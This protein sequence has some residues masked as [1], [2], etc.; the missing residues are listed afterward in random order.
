MP[1]SSEEEQDEKH[2]QYQTQ[3]LTTFTGCGVKYLCH[4]ESH[5]FFDHLSTDF[6]D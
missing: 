2:F 6:D 1:I 4:T 3:R 5:L